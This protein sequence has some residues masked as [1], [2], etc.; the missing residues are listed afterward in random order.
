MNRASSRN[1][2]AAI[3]SNATPSTGST[4]SRELDRRLRRPRGEER[5]GRGRDRVRN[6]I[7]AGLDERYDHGTTDRAGL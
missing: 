1:I 7:R 6:V 2:A 3:Q 4:P 5:Q